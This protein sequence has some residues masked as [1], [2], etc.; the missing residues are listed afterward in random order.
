MLAINTWSRDVLEHSGLFEAR[1]LHWRLGAHRLPIAFWFSGSLFG[2]AHTDCI[3]GLHLQSV[4]RSQHYHPLECCWAG[5]SWP[6]GFSCPGLD[7]L[8]LGQGWIL[9][10]GLLPLILLRISG[11]CKNLLKTDSRKLSGI[12][13]CGPTWDRPTLK[14]LDSCIRFYQNPSMDPDLSTDFPGKGFST[15]VSLNEL[16]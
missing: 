2:R 16:G 11:D 1:P 14:V 6:F 7:I 15:W 10:L 5:A 9:L 3:R 4:W 12:I 13:L 8:Y